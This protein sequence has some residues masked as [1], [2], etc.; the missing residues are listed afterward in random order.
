[1]HW[2]PCKTS[3]FEGSR[4]ASNRD[5]AQELDS[6]RYQGHASNFGGVAIGRDFAFKTMRHCAGKPT[7][8]KNGRRFTALSFERS[9]CVVS[10][11]NE[12]VPGGAPVTL[13]CL[14]KTFWRA[15]AL[16]LGLHTPTCAA[17]GGDEYSEPIGL[18]GAAAEQ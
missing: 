9:R 18:F 15:A 7:D 12:S 13:A 3:K 16:L 1:M 5:P 4:F 2:L 17:E 6:C 8:L 11:R 10:S 14:L